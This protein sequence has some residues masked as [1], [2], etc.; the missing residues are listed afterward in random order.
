[1]KAHEWYIIG[2]LEL[3]GSPP[4]LRHVYTSCP[5]CGIVRTQLEQ[6]GERVVAPDYWRVGGTGE[7]EFSEPP[8]WEGA[9]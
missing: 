2:R 7:P 6:H 1:L 3:A 4:D 8:C 5:R 9:A